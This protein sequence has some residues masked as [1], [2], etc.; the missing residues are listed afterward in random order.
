MTYVIWSVKNLPPS[1]NL[2]FLAESTTVKNERTFAISLRHRVFAS[3]KLHFPGVL[4]TNINS[5]TDAQT[6][7]HSLTRTL[8]THNRGAVIFRMTGASWF[9]ER[10]DGKKN[11][12]TFHPPSFTHRAN[13]LRLASSYREN[14][15]AG[16]QQEGPNFSPPK[17]SFRPQY[18]ALSLKNKMRTPPAIEE[19]TVCQAVPHWWSRTPSLLFGHLGTF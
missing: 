11:G 19:E 14:L 15:S 10:T 16:P 5:Q 4:G 6:H 13:K 2:C 3:W 8:Y 9:A 12:K 18:V 1:C 7:R 17:V